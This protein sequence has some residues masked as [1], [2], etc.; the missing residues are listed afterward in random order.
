MNVRGASVFIQ[1]LLNRTNENTM[2]TKI[3]KKKDETSGNEETWQEKGGRAGKG[4]TMFILQ[5]AI[6]LNRSV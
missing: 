6:R 5:K 4:G 2:E 3:K 1:K